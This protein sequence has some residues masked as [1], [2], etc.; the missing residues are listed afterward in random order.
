MRTYDLNQI[1]LN[2]Y[3]LLIVE[4]PTSLLKPVLFIVIGT[5]PLHHIS[6]KD[7]LQSPKWS[8]RFRNHKPQKLM[9]HLIQSLPLVCLIAPHWLLIHLQSEFWHLASLSL[10]TR[11]QS[12]ALQAPQVP[13]KGQIICLLT[14]CHQSVPLYVPIKSNPLYLQGLSIVCQTMAYI[15]SYH[16]FSRPW[17]HY[18]QFDLHPLLLK[19]HSI[20][21]PLPT[22]PVTFSVWIPVCTSAVYIVASGPIQGLIFN[23][24]IKLHTILWCKTGVCFRCKT[25][26]PDIQISRDIQSVALETTHYII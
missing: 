4:N 1:D 23:Y 9:C 22:F 12:T 8:L 20:C 7:L 18:M 6:I 24:S 13:I 19:P 25:Q 14:K 5:V 3:P 10:Y 21:S 2:P 15:F 11:S 16:Q 26:H 17:P